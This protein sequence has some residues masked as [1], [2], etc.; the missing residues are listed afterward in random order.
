MKLYSKTAICLLLDCG[1]GRRLINRIYCSCFKQKEA[2]VCKLLVLIMLS[3]SLFSFK[4]FNAH[5]C[6]EEACFMYL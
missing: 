4:W 1:G 6:A 3:K 2:E 5:N